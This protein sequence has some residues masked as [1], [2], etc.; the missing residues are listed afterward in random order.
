MRLKQIKLSAFKSFADYTVIHVPGQRVAV[1]GPNGCGK[2]NVIDAVR[3]VLG[4]SSA[5]QLRGQN[6]QD[7]IFNGASTRKPLSMASVELV[8]DN[9]SQSLG[10]AWGQYGEIAIK[11][12][13]NRNGDSRYQI[14]NQTVRRR[15]ITDLFLGTGVGARGYAV[16]EQGMISRII[17]SK[18]EDLRGFIEEAAGVSK[19]KERRR[20][21]E[22]RLK[23]AHSHLAR[24][25]DL[26]LE[27]EKQI[28]KLQRQAKTALRYRE[29]KNELAD[30]Q[31][32]LDYVLWQSALQ[33]ENDLSHKR[34]NIQQQ[35]DEVT[36]QQ[37]TLHETLYRQQ[38]AE[39]E[40]QEKMQAVAQERMR[41]GEAT[42]RLQEQIR[43]HHLL[44]Q[45]M[46]KEAL[47]AA[48]ESE[49]IVQRLIDLQTEKETNNLQCENAQITLEEYAMQREEHAFRLPEIEAQY[50]QWTTESEQWQSHCTHLVQTEALLQQSIERNQKDRDDLNTNIMALSLEDDDMPNLQEQS[51]QCD[52]MRE[53]MLDVDEKLSLLRQQAGNFDN[54]Q[55]ALLTQQKQWEK[56]QLADEL[57]LLALEKTLPQ[58]PSKTPWPSDANFAVLWQQIQVQPRWQ[59]ALSRCLGNRLQA[60]YAPDFKLPEAIENAQG[61][62]ISRADIESKNAIHKNELLSKVQVDAH[63]QAALNI[64]LDGIFC[65]EN[66]AEAIEKQNLLKEK[67]CFV[68]PEGHLIDCLSIAL[69][70]E[71]HDCLIERQAQCRQLREKINQNQPKLAKIQQQIT[72]INER[73]DQCKIEINTLTHEQNQLQNIL[74][75]HERK[76]ELDKQKVAMQEQ[77]MAQQQTQLAQWQAQ[78]EQLSTQETEQNQRWQDTQERLPEAQK[79]WAYAHHSAQTLQQELQQ[80]REKSLQLERQFHQSDMYLRTCQ[81]KQR[82]LHKEEE[83]LTTRRQA[84]MHHQ[85]SIDTTENQAAEQA[86]EKQQKEEEALNQQHDEL[87][88]IWKKSQ[89]QLKILHEQHQHISQRLP[90]I[91]NDFQAAL[92]LAKEAELLAEKHRQNLLQRGAD[93]SQLS[94][95]QHPEIGI[96]N[97]TINQL[98]QSLHRLGAVN[99]AAEEEL[100]QLRERHDY[101]HAQNEDLSSAIEQLNEAIAQIDRE[102]KKRF[103]DTFDEVN[104]HMQHYFPTLFGGGEAKLEL[105]DD[106]LLSTGI[107]IIAR[108]PGKKNSSIHLLSGGEKALCAMSL[109]FALFSLNPAPFCLL[110]EVDAPLDDAN[111]ARFCRLIEQMSEKT[112]FLYISHNRQTMES[113]EQLIGVTMQEKGVSR[114]V[115]VDIQAA[116]DTL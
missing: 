24:L 42:G 21:T 101:Y 58:N 3:W 75:Q 87:K 97:N 72:Q 99:L 20:E 1:V 106:D 76:L 102:S 83:T 73:Q 36:A 107:Q 61:V 39:H 5:K 63:F 112:Q 35:L 70:G 65:V 98:S 51:S 62:W 34:N 116:L 111:T 23:D 59:Y 17:E 95:L 68:T 22:S 64:W 91:Q 26:Q 86:L 110:D 32:A 56:E 88:E 10:G 18:P 37:N 40:T 46:E 54:E 77:K 74:N 94:I 100:H 105:T 48:H 113:A 109:V 103:K 57:E 38:L 78:L 31:N 104:R 55:A 49:R 108:P 4:E 114:I 6:M 15:D 53:S 45:K 92:L 80:L 27:L 30:A 16:I 85:E 9:H 67:E 44:R 25:A 82:Q 90:E 115:S 2:S 81:E 43:Q 50:A 93:I 13:L 7:V 89:H 8:F 69:A 12:S 52:I 33:E 19:Y 66:L 60:C 84:L 41:V 79:K 28:D 96:I 14:N 71:Q 11:R 47:A 29:I